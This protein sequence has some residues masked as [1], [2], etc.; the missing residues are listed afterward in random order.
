MSDSDIEVEL[1]PLIEQLVQSDSLRLVAHRHGVC[2]DAADGMHS[3]DMDWE[4]QQHERLLAR[5]KHGAVIRPQW[6]VQALGEVIV[7]R[8]A[9]QASQDMDALVE[10][11]WLS[12]LSARM[13]GQA[14]DLAR[15]IL[16]VGPQVLCVE[17]AAA[18]LSSGK[19]PA[20]VAPPHEPLADSWT[21]LSD[22]EEVSIYG[23]DRIGAWSL[24]GRA[25]GHLMGRCCSVVGWFESRDLQQALVRFER[26]AADPLGS[27]SGAMQVLAAVDLVVVADNHR[28]PR[29]S[30]IAEICL[31]PE[32]YRPQILFTCGI[33]PMPQVLVPVAAPSFVN[34]LREAG[35]SLLAN[36]LAMAA[37]SYSSPQT[38]R[39]ATHAVGSTTEIS[40]GYEGGPPDNDNTEL[41]KCQPRQEATTGPMDVPTQPTTVVK[42]P[43]TAGVATEPG[44]ELDQLDEAELEKTYESHPDDAVMAATYGL[45]PPPK[46]FGSA[47]VGAA[48]DRT[49]A[50]ALARAQAGQ[51][52]WQ[53][54]LGKIRATTT[55][56][57]S[58]E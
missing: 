21:R 37:P 51:N 32:G 54:Q 7:V 3:L 17:L 14:M 39:E 8:R 25:L 41:D 12:L 42:S 53:Q 24:D 10:R 47:P 58:S 19:R 15:N 29:V 44:W 26:C 56:D 49:F 31:T 22:A 20:V 16:L 4:S 40:L 34:E 50:D 27:S 30:Q 57:E 1:A 33:D 46:P 45:G 23:P 18:L 5:L 11:G 48:A 55:E 43:V 36:E 28:T 9:P 2:L 13:L 52:N 35:D 6:C 38:R